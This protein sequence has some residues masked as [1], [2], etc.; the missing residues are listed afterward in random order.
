M[1]IDEMSAGGNLRVKSG[2]ITFDTKLTFRSK[3]ICL[4]LA[5]HLLTDALWFLLVPRSARL[6]FLVQLSEEMWD[7]ADDGE[8]YFEKV[9]GFLRVPPTH[10]S[11]MAFS[12]I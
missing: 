9:I 6:F 8:L 11:S 4:P 12:C 10:L 1:K 2:L 7:Y 5:I 3:Y